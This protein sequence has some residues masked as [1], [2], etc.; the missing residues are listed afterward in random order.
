MGLKACWPRSLKL[1]RGVTGRGGR[2]VLG[3]VGMFGIWFV[4]GSSPGHVF[5]GRMRSKMGVASLRTSGLK[6]ID[7]RRDAA[8]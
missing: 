1:P 2:R 3:V 7:V 8:H 4:A 6:T 5:K